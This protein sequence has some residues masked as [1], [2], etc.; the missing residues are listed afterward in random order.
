MVKYVARPLLARGG[1]NDKV[2]ELSRGIAALQTQRELRYLR[3]AVVASIDTT[4]ITVI[5]P[6]QLRTLVPS[7]NH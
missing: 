5:S 4:P 2:Q 3:N 1:D 7:K 6:R